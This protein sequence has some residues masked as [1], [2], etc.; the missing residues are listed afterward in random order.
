MERAKFGRKQVVYCASNRYGE[1]NQNGMAQKNEAG[2]K[3]FYENNLYAR[4]KLE[5]LIN[6]EDNVNSQRKEMQ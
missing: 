3:N 1:R 4:H 6:C 2:M 5:R